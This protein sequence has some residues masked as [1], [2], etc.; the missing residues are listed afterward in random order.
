MKTNIGT[1]ECRYGNSSVLGYESCRLIKL[2]NFR[3]AFCIHLYVYKYWDSQDV[4]NY[5]PLDKASHPESFD[6]PSMP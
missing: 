5:L 1:A 4:G 3:G 6:S 2:P